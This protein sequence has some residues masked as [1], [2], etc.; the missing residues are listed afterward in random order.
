MQI[1]AKFYNVSKIFM[2]Q[3]NLKNSFRVVTC[4]DESPF[5]V[6]FSGIFVSLSLIKISIWA[7]IDCNWAR[8]LP[9]LF[10]LVLRVNSGDPYILSLSVWIN[11]FTISWV[12]MSDTPHIYW[13]VTQLLG[14]RVCFYYE[15]DPLSLSLK[16]ILSN[17][18]NL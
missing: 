18:L 6:T 17:C 13:D 7:G 4:I 11:L 5:L 14:L 9:E 2:L 16:K 1:V 12:N 3:L 15:E 8:F 10:L